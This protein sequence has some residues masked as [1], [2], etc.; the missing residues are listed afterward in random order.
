MDVRHRKSPDDPRRAAGAPADPLEF[1]PESRARWEW[2]SEEIRRVG[3]RVVDLIAAHLTKL[4]E[5]PVFRPYQGGGGRAARGAAAH[6]GR[7]RRRDPRPLRARLDPYP[8]GNGHPRFY[9]WVNSPPVPLG[10]FADALAAAMNPSCRWRQPRGGLVERQVLEWFKQLLAFPATSAG[11]LVSGA[12]TA[13]LT[14][15]AVAR[16]RAFARLAAM[17]VR[18]ASRPRARGR[19][20]ATRRLSQRRGPRLSPES[21]RAPRTRPRQ[22]PHRA[23][24]CRTSH[25]ARGARCDADR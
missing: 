15:L 10:I 1:P 21:G 16:H 14:A 24:R 23:D 7:E 11:V 19:P 25:A 3:Y 12:S 8:F 18:R 20:A 2:S 5:R 22:P 4:P 6:R 9:G 17:C 13:A